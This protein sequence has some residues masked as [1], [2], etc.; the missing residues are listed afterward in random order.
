M[1]IITLLNEKGGVGKTTMAATIGAGLAIMGYRVMLIDADPQGHLT[2]SFGIKRQYSLYN[3]L[4][5]DEEFSKPGIVVPVPPEVYA[6]PNA[7]TPS[8]GRLF[9][10]PG[11]R[12]TRLIAQALEGETFAVRNK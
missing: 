1:K 5:R 12:E 4:V 11:N 2:L 6:L 10:V 9:I 8:T 7:K 3:L